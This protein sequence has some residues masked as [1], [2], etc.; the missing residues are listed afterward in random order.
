MAERPTIAML[1]DVNKVVIGYHVYDTGQLIFDEGHSTDEVVDWV[2][3]TT[4]VSQ[5]EVGQY[6]TLESANELT[7]ELIFM[8][9][10]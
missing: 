3:A 8:E 5:E 2:F 1:R 7:Q 9:S 6:L 4:Y 10:R